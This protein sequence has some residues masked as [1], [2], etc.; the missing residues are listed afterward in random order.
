MLK[1]YY[2]YPIIAYRFLFRKTAN[3]YYNKRKRF[4]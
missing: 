2:I 4:P 1:D 3:S